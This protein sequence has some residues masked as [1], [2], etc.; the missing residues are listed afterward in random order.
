MLFRSLSF[1]KKFRSRKVLKNKIFKIL[2]FKNKNIKFLN[3]KNI[4]FLNIK[5][6]KDFKTFFESRKSIIINNFGK[7]FSYFYLH[8]LIKKNNIPQVQI[9]N[10]DIVSFQRRFENKL[11]YKKIF[12][13][14]RRTLPSKLITFLSIMKILPK[15]DLCFTTNLNTINQTSSYNFFGENFRY[16]KSTIP[17]NSAAYDESLDFK[18]SNKYILYIDT[19]VNHPDSIQSRG[20]LSHEKVLLHYEL[21]R[22]FLKIKIGRAHV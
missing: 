4:K 3:I 14:F 6:S 1:F 8:Y 18:I 2:N 7:T 21:V 10:I 9:L 16:I 5:S 15:I 13:F 12:Y 22:K 19:N 11:F 17:I 20:I